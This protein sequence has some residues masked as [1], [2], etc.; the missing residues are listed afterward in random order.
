MNCIKTQEYL[1]ILQGN[2]KNTHR[3]D[4]PVRNQYINVMD[5]YSRGQI[6]SHREYTVYL[7]ENSLYVYLPAFASIGV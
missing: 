7:A 5:L 3:K 1:P 4:S 6:F 2:G